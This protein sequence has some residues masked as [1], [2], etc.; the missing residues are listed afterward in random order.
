MNIDINEMLICGKL[1]I[2]TDSKGNNKSIMSTSVAYNPIYPDTFVIKFDV[3]SETKK[4]STK[5]K[6]KSTNRKL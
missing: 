6:N 2:L 4:K 5:R 1:Y 3:L